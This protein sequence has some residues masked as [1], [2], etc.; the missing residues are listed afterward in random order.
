MDVAT[1]FL[2]GILSKNLEPDECLEICKGLYGLVQ[3]SRVFYLKFSCYLVEEC[4]F[5]RSKSDQ[6]VFCKVGKKGIII[7]FLSM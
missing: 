6:C 3:S 7:L 4:D 5:L 2:G 1:A